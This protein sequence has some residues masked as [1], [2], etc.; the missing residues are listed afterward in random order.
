[1]NNKPSANVIEYKNGKQVAKPTSLE[2]LPLAVVDLRDFL[3][4]DIPPRLML[5]D[6][7]LPT[8]GLAMGYGWRGTGKTWF[9]LSVAYTVA[10]GGSFLG[11][12]V[13]QASKVLYVDG[14][15]AGADLQSRL[16]LI[17]AGCEWEPGPGMLNLCTP[18]LQARGMPDLAT[19]GGLAALQEAMPEDTKL[20]IIDS[21]SS[22]VRGEGNEN[23]AESW[24]SVAEWAIA[25]K[26]LGR[27]I[28]FMHHSGK[29]GAQRGTSKREDLLDSVLAFRPIPDHRP[30]EG[31]KFQ[32]LIDKARGRYPS[33]RPIEAELTS[34][35]NG[36]VCW[37]YRTIEESL[38]EKILELAD[39]GSKQ[40][41]I[42]KDLGC[43][44]STVMRTLRRRKDVA[45]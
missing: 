43:A 11:W 38:S 19:V 16:S 1:M 23:D 20:I 39:E 30:N 18:D 14:E 22:L 17:A 29:S 5:I 42:A 44:R 9:A 10:S 33:F 45:G 31:A 40:A 26:V 36:G 27:S 28:L 12:N 34:G 4:M 21:I 13:P 41:D 3:A 8:Q 32:I 15:M 35:K 25:Q 37:T 6:P 7:W 24:L 2:F